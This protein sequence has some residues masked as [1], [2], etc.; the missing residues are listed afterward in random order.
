MF[1]SFMTGI[2]ITGIAAFLAYPRDLPTKAD[3]SE[4]QI[5]IQR[6]VDLVETEQAHQKDQMADVRIDIGKIKEKLRIDERR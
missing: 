1:A 4:T 2:V 5:S 6:Q 3:L